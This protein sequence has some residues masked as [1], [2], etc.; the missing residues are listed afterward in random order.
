MPADP[1]QRP[2]RI[3]LHLA[4]VRERLDRVPPDRLD[5]E[6]AAGALLVDIRPIAD[7][8]REGPLPGAVVVDRNVLEWR[9][10]PTS[11][12]RLPEV[13][14]DLERRIILCCN[15][16]YAS[17]LAAEQLHD[18]GLTGATDLAGGYRGWRRA[19]HLTG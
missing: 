14:G 5:D 18:L 3:G 7:R 9:L 2:S 11:P 10:D 8:I 13:D 1:P 4:A 16:G 6:I 12:D 17:S 15:D 19:A